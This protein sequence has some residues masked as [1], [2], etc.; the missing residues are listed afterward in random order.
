MILTIEITDS[1][2]FTHCIKSN[3]VTDAGSLA[4]HISHYIETHNKTCP[5]FVSIVEDEVLFLY[6]ADNI[7]RMYAVMGDDG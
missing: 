1:R 6:N 2:K 4:T 5:M 3:G 7:V